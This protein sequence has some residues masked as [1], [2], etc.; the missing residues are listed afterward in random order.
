MAVF[1]EVSRA[2][3]E[4]FI[5]QFNLGAL[6][7]VLPTQTGSEN[8]NYIIHTFSGDYI[9]TLYEGRTNVEY[10]REMVTFVDCLYDNG[11]VVPEILESKTGGRVK[12]LK[13][14][15][16]TIQIFV[17]GAVEKKPSIKQCHLAGA[18]LAKIHNLSESSHLPSIPANQTFKGWLA[19]ISEILNTAQESHFIDMAKALKAEIEHLVEAPI[20]GV[21]QGLVHGDY[22]RDNVFFDADKV[23]GVIDFWM[24]STE[25]F[26]YDLAIAL[27][28]WGFDKGDFLEDHYNAF[29]NGYE[30]ERALTDEEKLAL[31]T[32]L[33]RACVRFFISR[34][35]DAVHGKD[36]EIMQ[37]K[38]AHTWYKRLK[39]FQEQNN[40]V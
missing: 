15:P 33:R 1:T 20:Q 32:E 27:N 37:E 28:V 34:L 13:G 30:E 3:I 18:E 26:V 19:D 21:R 22:F 5:E 25:N 29:L 8:T 24:C 16:A 4:A 12:E 2:E 35:Y 11:A 40:N 7:T 23:S 36:D 17:E 38:P 9:L 39:F 6:N 14:L 31:P 10:I